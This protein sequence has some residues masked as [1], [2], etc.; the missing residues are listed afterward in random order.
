MSTRFGARN[1]QIML[2]INLT[3]TLQKAYECLLI[4]KS[5]V[6]KIADYEVTIR[7]IF[8]KHSN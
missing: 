6:L 1:P 8:E 5:S 2:E 7:M 4:Q 3:V